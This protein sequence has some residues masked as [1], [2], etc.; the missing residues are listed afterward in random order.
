MKL[1]KA[2]DDP[3]VNVP[4]HYMRGLKK[5]AAKYTYI[6]YT[7]KEG[8]IVTMSWP[9]KKNLTKNVMHHN[10]ISGPL[11][12]FMLTGLYVVVVVIITM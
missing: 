9:I 4:T 7:L 5:F 8:G 11:L 10:L 1:I 6:C 3:R 12:F 2:S